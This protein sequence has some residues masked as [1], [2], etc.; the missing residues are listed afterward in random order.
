MSYENV[1]DDTTGSAEYGV[2]MYGFKD[3]SKVHDDT[4]SEI[5]EIN[6]KNILR[7]IVS[8]EM[9][10]EKS[11]KEHNDSYLQWHRLYEKEKKYYERFIL[12]IESLLLNMCELHNIKH[13][14]I[15]T[16]IKTFNSF[17]NKIFKRAN[18]DTESKKDDYRKAITNPIVHGDFVFDDIR[19]IAGI[20]VICYLNNHVKTLDNSYSL[21]IKLI[22]TIEDDKNTP[23]EVTNRKM[24]SIGNKEKHYGDHN[25]EYIYENHY[26]GFHC[27]IKS[28]IDNNAG[29]LF[30]NLTLSNGKPVQC[31]V[32]IRTVLAHGFSE[33][34]HGLNYKSKNK[35]SDAP[36]KA[37]LLG[38]SKQLL[39]TDEEIDRIA[40]NNQ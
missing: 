36:S 40:G 13:H 20:R 8:C 12:I 17:Y 19:D 37:D 7:K 5:K 27:T 15:Q 21:G 22:K 10:I 2:M 23:L 30:R 24:I 35:D 11:I 39:K 26:R 1:K 34:E 38:I 32:Q 28:K 6:Y 29:I 31:E 18:D 14:M 9:H 16:R 25:I 33:V 4:I 3:N